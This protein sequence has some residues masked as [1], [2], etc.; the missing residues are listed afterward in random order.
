M[1][2]EF[3]RLYIANV[4]FVFFFCVAGEQWYRNKGRVII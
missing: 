3:S 1:V 4:G 2:F